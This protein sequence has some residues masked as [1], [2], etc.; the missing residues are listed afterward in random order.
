MHMFN[1]AVRDAVRGYKCH[2]GTCIEEKNTIIVVL[3]IHIILSQLNRNLQL[4]I[5]LQTPYR[6]DNSSLQEVVSFTVYSI[7]RHQYKNRVHKCAVRLTRNLNA[8]HKAS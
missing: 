7:K 8:S 3:R 2:K 1:S 5:S 4:S 6:G